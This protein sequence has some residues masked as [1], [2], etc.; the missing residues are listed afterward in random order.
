MSLL[1]TPADVHVLSWTRPDFCADG[2]GEAGTGTRDPVPE[3]PPAVGS[4]PGTRPL[5]F[6]LMFV[7]WGR[8]PTDPG[9]VRTWARVAGTWVVLPGPAPALPGKMSGR[10]GGTGRSLG[11]RPWGRLVQGPDLQ[12]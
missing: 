5:W 9:K 1:L 8:R 4:W 2:L 12:L 11:W 10:H 7:L 6:S 3:G